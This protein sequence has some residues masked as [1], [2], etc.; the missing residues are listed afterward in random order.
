MTTKLEA[1]NTMLNCIG[2]IPINTLEGSVTK[3]TFVVSA[4]NLLDNETRRIQLTEWDFNTEDNYPLTPNTDNIIKLPENVLRVKFPQD[5]M[6]RY[7]IRD[8]KIYDKVEHTFTISTPLYVTIV[9]KLDFDELPEV[10][11]TY[12]TMSSAYKLT[13]RELG[14]QAPCLYTQEDLNE[15]KAQMLQYELDTGN[16]SM[17]PQFYTKEITR[18]L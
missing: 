18:E 9:F 3:S 14:A 4:E 6:N 7:I 5:F 11:Q 8:N 15:A 2:Q 1:I 12:I 17:I 10:V 13:K 16:Y